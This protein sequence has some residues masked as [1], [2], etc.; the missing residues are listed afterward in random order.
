MFWCPGFL[1]FWCFGVLVSCCSPTGISEPGFDKS[2][3]GKR[4][5]LCVLKRGHFKETV[6][7]L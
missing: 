6:D 4:V 5:N 1:V 3:A 2:E 7:G